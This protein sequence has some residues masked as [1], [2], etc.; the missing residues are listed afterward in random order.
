MGEQVKWRNK[1][2]TIAMDAWTFIPSLPSTNMCF[3]VVR[4]F[5]LCTS[6]P[7]W[8]QSSYFYFILDEQEGTRA[9]AYVLLKVERE[10]RNQKPSLSRTEYRKA[11]IVGESPSHSN[12]ISLYNPQDAQVEIFGFFLSR[13][14][15]EKLIQ[16]S[17]LSSLRGPFVSVSIESRIWK[18]QRTFF[19]RNLEA[20]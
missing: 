8:N 16:R 5:F 6:F 3:F 13:K 1:N 4:L 11:T 15:E 10:N 19:L 18:L 7:K 9:A 20:K 2:W 17:I 12:L 14:V